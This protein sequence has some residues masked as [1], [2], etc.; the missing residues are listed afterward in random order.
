ME[1]ACAVSPHHDDNDDDGKQEEKEGEE[2][3]EKNN[4]KDWKR[5]QQ[6]NR[7][8][9]KGVILQCCQYLNYIEM[10]GRMSGGYWKES[11]MKGSWPNGDIIL[12]TVW[13]D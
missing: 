5:E 2:E 6:F 9:G 3:E 10:N 1:W 11:G 13:K 12:T 8:W 4:Y 7:F